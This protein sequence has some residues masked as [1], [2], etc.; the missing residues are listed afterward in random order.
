VRDHVVELARDACPLLDNR[1]A[2]LLF[3]LAFENHRTVLEELL[4]SSPGADEPADDERSK[5]DDAEENEAAE[6]D[7]VRVPRG[8]E[9]PECDRE[10]AGDDGLA[11]ARVR[12][13]GVEAHEHE[14][15]ESL[16]LARVGEPEVRDRRRYE[17]A[18]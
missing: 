6:V 10:E 2:R 16:A 9:D 5:D 4:T 12:A 14:N 15:P 7:A 17:G 3:A 11:S 18:E 8:D 13:R 1:R